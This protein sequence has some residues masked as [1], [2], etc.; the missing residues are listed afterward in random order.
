MEVD[1]TRMCELL[2]GLGEVDLVGVD[3]RGWDEPLVVVIRS[4]R[5]RPVCEGCGGRVWSK[6]YR[7]VVLVDLP[8]FGRPVRL[9]WRK[10]RWMCPSPGCAV[11]S[12]VEQDPS[13]GPERALLTS[14]AARWVTVQVGKAGRSVQEVA[15]ELGCDWHTVNSEVGRWGEALLEADTSRVGQ[16][17]AVGVDETLFWRQGRWRTK[18]WCTSVVDVGGR[19]LIDIVPGR[20][21]ESAARWFR[22]Q[23]AEWRDGIRWAVLDLSGPYRTA[24]DR[25]L[26]NAHQVADPFHVVR[27][28]NQRLDEVRRRVQNET[29]GHRGRKADPLYRIRRLLTSAS[30]RISDRGRTR[31][32]GLLDA[33][34]P[35]GEVRDAWHAKET[36]RGIYGIDSIPT[37]LRYVLQ[38]GDD[39]QDPSLPPEIN[40]LGRT[41]VRWAPQIANWHI[42]K[43]T[44]GPTEALNNL[45][46]RVKRAAFGFRNFAN[47][48]IRAL[49]YAGKPNWDLLA[50]V[51]PH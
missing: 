1:P 25:V 29:L 40:Q 11:R 51:T 42:S 37:A 20:T 45:I 39:L 3:D 30:E 14:R 7:S 44:N 50:T 47:Y 12:F 21:A 5:P 6:G 27:L 16:V 2:V 22:S 33:G 17:E 32:R 9:R 28:A 46:K 36:V 19:R 15:A 18:V 48:R 43:V 8:A 4:R 26:P 13:I 24:Y 10:R 35:Y 23:P 41:I 49:L 34:D 31:L 38:L